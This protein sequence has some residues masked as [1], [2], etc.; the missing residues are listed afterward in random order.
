[1]F[2]LTFIIYRI[3]LT[4]ISVEYKLHTIL[5]SVKTK[6]PESAHRQAEAQ[7]LQFFY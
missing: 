2:D 3:A 5:R 7:A 4:N 6:T 1:M